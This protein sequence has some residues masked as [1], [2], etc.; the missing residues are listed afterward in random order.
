MPLNAFIVRPF[1]TKEVIVETTMKDIHPEARVVQ[2]DGREV[3]RLVE[4]EGRRRR[5]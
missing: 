4:G 2:H 1:G 5:R 3:A